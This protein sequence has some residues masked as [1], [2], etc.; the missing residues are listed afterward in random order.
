MGL[1]RMGSPHGQR[2]CA[3][4][5]ECH[6]YRLEE[7]NGVSCQSDPPSRNTGGDSAYVPIGGARFGFLGGE[8]VALGEIGWSCGY[9]V[10]KE[11]GTGAGRT[12]AVSDG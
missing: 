10:K 1:S 8:T 7:S 3:A 12:S 6:Y 11:P 9:G 4:I 2:E 5:G